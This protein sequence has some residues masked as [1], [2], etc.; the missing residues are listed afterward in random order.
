MHTNYIISLPTAIQRR[1]HIK[2][3]F[4]KQDIPFEF[5]NALMPSEQLNQLIQKYLPNLSQASLSEGKNVLMKIYVI[6]SF[7]KMIFFWVKMLTTF[8][9]RVI[10]G[11]LIYF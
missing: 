10:I 9:L 4:G 3:E 2:Q 8:Y 5:Y 7:L 6:F 11:Y 1:E